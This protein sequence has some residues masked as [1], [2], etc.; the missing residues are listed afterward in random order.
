MKYSW[1]SFFG[2]AHSNNVKFSTKFNFYPNVCVPRVVRFVKN[3]LFKFSNEKKTTL[4]TPFFAAADWFCVAAIELWMRWNFSKWKKF[5]KFYRHWKKKKLKNGWK[6]TEMKKLLK[7]EMI[8]ALWTSMTPTPT[9]LMMIMV[10][11]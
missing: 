11:F 3:S 8:Y 2:Y 7:P 5:W 9:P 1:A 6:K 10:V 4:K